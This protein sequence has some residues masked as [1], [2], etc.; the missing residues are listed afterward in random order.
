ML[1]IREFAAFSFFYFCVAEAIRH[2]AEVGSIHKGCGT[3]PTHGSLFEF[4]PETGT[5]TAD[6]NP[7]NTAPDSDIGSAPLDD[8]MG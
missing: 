4:R 3:N 5:P 2:S 7:S 8:D 1:K 6:F